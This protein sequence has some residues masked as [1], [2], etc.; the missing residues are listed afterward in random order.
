MSATAQATLPVRFP[1]EGIVPAVIQDATS[2]AVL[3][4][5]FM[6]ETALVH[7]R[8]TGLVHFWSRSRH[9][10]WQKGESSGH[11]QQVRDIYVNCDQNSLLIQVDQVGAVC[12]DGYPTCYYRRLEPDN[13][14]RI[15]RDRWFDPE[16][17]YGS[18]QGLAGTTARWWGAYA[19]LRERDLTPVSGTSRVL[20]ND[21]PVTS[22]IADELRE[23][24]GVLDGTHL[25]NGPRTDAM[26]EGGQ[27]CYWTVVEA[28]RRGM[29]W[30]EVR[31]DRAL[32]REGGTEALPVTTLAALLHTEA[33]EVSRDGLDSAR[34]H[35]IF[36]LVA[37][38]CVA[39]G[40]LPLDLIL[41][42]LEELRGRSY[43]EEYFAR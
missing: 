43:L 29:T 3:M 42:D 36:S 16:D 35:A 13:S 34:A 19:S 2:G 20:R 18:G 28:V 8:E 12:H 37:D 26:L 5:G 39:M 31:P 15:V 33:A 14:L 17:L 27:V 1:E 7:T 11:V 41:R 30:D 23:L 25:H 32:D 22:R 21:Q 38:V 6:N 24:A 4:V 10:L 40:I 9:R